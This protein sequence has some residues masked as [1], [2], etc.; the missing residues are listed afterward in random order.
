MTLRSLTVPGWLRRRL[1]GLRGFWSGPAATPVACDSERSATGAPPN[2][3]SSPAAARVS[4]TAVGPGA[5]A[6]ISARGDD[7]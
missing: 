4:D 7:H 6:P 1:M 5:L 2:R 3:T